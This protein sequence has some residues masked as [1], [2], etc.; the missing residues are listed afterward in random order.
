MS[1]IQPLLSGS[2]GEEAGGGNVSTILAIEE[3]MIPSVGIKNNIESIQTMV[4]ESLRSVN[5]LD[6]RFHMT[7]PLL[8]DFHGP[9]LV[10]NMNKDI[11]NINNNLGDINFL[12]TRIL[13]KLE[14]INKHL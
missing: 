10:R 2:N 5:D 14:V 1:E 4:K 13:K 8:Q 6:Q 3:E 9:V 12:L 11:C 7:K